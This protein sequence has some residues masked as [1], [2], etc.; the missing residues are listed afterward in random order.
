MSKM[1]ERPR[2]LR[3]REKLQRLG[4]NNLSDYELLMAIIGSGNAKADVT[5]IAR[6]VLKLLKDK[7]GELTYDDLLQITAL[8][9]AKA[10]QIMASYELWRRRFEVSGRPEIQRLSDVVELVGDIRQKKQEHLLCL[11]LDGANRLINKRIITVGTVNSS[12]VHPREVY[13]DAITDRAAGIIVVH[14]HPSG[15]IEPSQPDLESTKRLRDAGDILGI[16]LIDHLIITADSYNS[17][18][19]SPQWY[20]YNN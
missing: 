18:L 11:T 16:P 7:E 19:S 14:N 13:A 9:P 20:A 2:D 12:L 5:K 6:E 4:A 8:G 10:T 3:P 15:T 17:I 1:S